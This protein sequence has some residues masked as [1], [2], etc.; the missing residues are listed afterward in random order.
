MTYA[1]TFFLEPAQVDDPDQSDVR[2]YCCEPHSA[3]LDRR[4]KRAIVGPGG[5]QVRL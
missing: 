4:R 3:E 2:V 5:R 1:P